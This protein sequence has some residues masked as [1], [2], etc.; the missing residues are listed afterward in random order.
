MPGRR[1]RLGLLALGLLG[2]LARVVAWRARPDLHPDE[3]FQYLEPA[4]R[5]LHGYGWLAWEWS[6]G[7]RSW[8]LPTYH[9]AWM[10]LLDWAGVQS[11]ELVHAF[12][13]LHWAFASLLLLPAAW[14]AGR[15]MAAQSWSG[16]LR[17]DRNAN[18]PPGW[19]GGLLSVAATA[20]LPTLA[21]FSPHTLTEVPSMLALVWGYTLWLEARAPAPRD[22]AFRLGLATGLLLSLG[23]LLRIA[24]GPLVLVPIFDLVVRRRWRGLAG[25]LIGC[26]LVA[27]GFGLVDW[28]THGSPFHSLRAYLEYNYVEGRAAEHGV[29]PLGHYARWMSD[30]LGFG[31]LLLLAPIALAFRAVWGW[32]LGVLLLFVALSTQA[33][34]EE[35][36]LLVVWPMLTIAFGAASGRLMVRLR[37][38][39]RRAAVWTLIAGL[40]AG[41]IARNIRG[42]QERDQHDYSRRWALYAAQAWAGRQP[43]AT[44]VLV[45]GAFHLSGGW[46]MLGKNLPLDSYGPRAENPL[47]NYFVVRRDSAE[48]QDGVARGAHA[49]H[50][51]GP[52]V[53]LRR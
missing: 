38:R 14:R 19:E 37:G 41:A 9:G 28:V 30:R 16:R 43:D 25:L 20:L 45:E 42:I 2:A 3:F 10:V 26:S 6:L 50:V 1:L 47:Y 44:G 22:R 40:G 13:Q 52:F 12:L 24:N 17:D 35:R 11:G 34:K 46:L 39:T 5:H 48:E 51:R 7:L 32:A 49:V 36:F 31:L 8:V 29:A 27:T 15:R 4:W 23:A 33:H 18:L 53:V 21:Y